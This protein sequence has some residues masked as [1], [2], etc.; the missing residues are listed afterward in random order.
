M[1]PIRKTVAT[2]VSKATPVSNPDRFRETTQRWEIEAGPLAGTALDYSFHD[3]WS[4]TW[5]EVTG[6]RQGEKGRARQFHVEPVA[7]DLYLLSFSI[8]ASVV[9]TVALDFS[10]YRMVGFRTG[11][12]TSI[13]IRGMFRPL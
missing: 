2:P 1:F 6:P 7:A 10:T 8:A 4:V 12:G 11:T 3:D 5:R 13:S 9:L